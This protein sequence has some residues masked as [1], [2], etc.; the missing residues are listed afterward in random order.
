MDAQIWHLAPYVNQGL[1][2]RSAAS[3]G[4]ECRKV[5]TVNALRP[6]AA[7]QRS[8]KSA[9]PTSRASEACALTC[10]GIAG[11]WQGAERAQLVNLRPRFA[12]GQVV[13]V[14][15]SHRLRHQPAL[16]ARRAEQSGRQN[17][18]KGGFRQ[19]RTAGLP[20]LLDIGL[21]VPARPATVRASAACH[22]AAPAINCVNSS[23]APVP[24]APLPSMPW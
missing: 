24:P 13:R 18:G 16:L 23:A 7:W 9:R 2:S 21:R 20:L 15:P 10:V 5:S 19:K 8:R 6:R 17:V 14:E 22:T 4:A 1:E 11:A 3:R 12:D